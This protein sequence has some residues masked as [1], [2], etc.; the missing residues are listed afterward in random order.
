M[1]FLLPLDETVL[2]SFMVIMSLCT[3]QLVRAAARGLFPCAFHVPEEDQTG[4]LVCGL[5]LCRECPDASG[6]SL[7]GGL[8]V[9]VLCV[10]IHIR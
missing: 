2:W 8:E 4:E 5:L 6:H 1:L 7:L 9:F 3:Q 10:A